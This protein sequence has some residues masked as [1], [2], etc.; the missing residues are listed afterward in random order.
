[1][2]TFVPYPDARLTAQCLDRQ[3]LGK[4]RV[5]AVQILRTLLGLS[6][7][8][9]HHPAVVMWK[10]HEHFL[11]AYTIAI[12]A[13]WERRGYK[14]TKIAQHINELT[15]CLSRKDYD[16]SPPSWWTDDRVHSSHRSALLRKDN[17]HY[18]QFEWQDSPEAPYYW[19][20]GKKEQNG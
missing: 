18:S 15:D 20:D 19:P 12:V 7:G 11:L 13:E 14:N 2:Q 16:K 1:M 4:Q 17:K 9:S 5:E 6:T 8:W 3:R 10:G